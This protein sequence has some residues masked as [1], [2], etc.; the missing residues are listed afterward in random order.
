M[1]RSS[2]IDFNNNTS[3]ILFF[4]NKKVTKKNLLKQENFKRRHFILCNIAKC[5]ATKVKYN[6]IIGILQYA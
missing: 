5:F 1:N 6:T 2:F 3:T 4:Q